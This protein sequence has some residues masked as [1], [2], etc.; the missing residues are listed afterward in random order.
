MFCAISKCFCDKPVHVRITPG[1]SAPEM[2]RGFC[3]YYE[4]EIDA[5]AQDAWA[6]GCII[7]ALYCEQELFEVG[8]VN[9]P[10]TDY[11]E[12]HDRWVSPSGCTVHGMS[13]LSFMLRCQL[14]SAVARLHDTTNE[15]HELLSCCIYR[16][17]SSQVLQ[18]LSMCWKSEPRVTGCCH[19]TM[20]CCAL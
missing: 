4:E 1:S 9:A 2:V 5:T 14:H 10:Y 15:L 17:T 11:M 20:V 19:S 12:L 3:G 7:M 8:I 6:L 16:T 13:C 18:C